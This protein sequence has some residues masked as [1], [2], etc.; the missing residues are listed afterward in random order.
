[1][2]NKFA[3]FAN[4][5]ETI[6]CL[7]KDKQADAYKAICEFG[8]YGTLPDDV[9]L[10]SLCLMA[11]NSI[12]KNVGGAPE[13]NKNAQ[14]KQPKTT[15]NNLE[16][17]SKQPMFQETRNKKQETETEAE[18]ESKDSGKPPYAFSGS[19]IRLNQK[20]FD[21]WKEMF[22]DLNLRAEL[23]I[24]DKFLEKQSE[25]ERKKWFVSTSQ[26]FI[27][28]NERRKVQNRELDSNR[29]DSDDEKCWF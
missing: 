5:A 24:R 16:T 27:K 7:P 20:D 18:T 13:G 3:F 12:Y 19:V 6:R 2:Q 10:K 22:P 17:T 11:Q 29:N 23:M 14:K 8:I 26:Y 1:M 21:E 15:Q 9:L 28:Q 25:E 4:F